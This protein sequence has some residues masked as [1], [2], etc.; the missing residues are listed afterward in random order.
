[1]ADQSKETQELNRVL[2]DFVAK[3]SLSGDVL[4]EFMRLRELVIKQTERVALLE[5]NAKKSLADLFSMRGE[6][7]KLASEVGAA[8]SY[9]DACEK[10]NAAMKIIDA[11][12]VARADTVFEC[13]RLVFRNSEV[14]R[15]LTSN[16]PVAQMAGYPGGGMSSTV[17]AFQQTDQ[18]I[19]RKE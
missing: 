6:R 9:A 12:A 19:E 4:G 8:K 16:V 11:A 7:D 3:R 2:E 14:H 1:M 15:T 18:V 5:E 10:S 17:G 13:F